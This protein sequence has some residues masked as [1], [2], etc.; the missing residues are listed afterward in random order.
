MRRMHDDPL[1]LTLNG[2]SSSIKFA[3]F[4]PPASSGA[5]PARRLAG[6]ID[7]IGTSAATF[8]AGQDKTPIAAA[9]H[10]QAADA[11]DRLC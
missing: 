1:I 3:L 5:R 2:G 11:A 8:T 7:R 10:Q 9:T 6:S 4:S